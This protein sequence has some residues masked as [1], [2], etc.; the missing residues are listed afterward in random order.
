MTTYGSQT[1]SSA[2][3]ERGLS[4]KPRPD[5]RG[6]VLMQD[7]RDV[8]PMTV[9]VGWC[10]VRLLDKASINDCR[11]CDVQQAHKLLAGTNH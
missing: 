8:G 6:R 5:N 11:R 1:L 4:S 7:T 9:S 10:L 3:R 2:L